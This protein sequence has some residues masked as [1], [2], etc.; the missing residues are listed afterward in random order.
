MKKL[1]A[2]AALALALILALGLSSC[3]KENPISNEEIFDGAN[4]IRLNGFSAEYNGSPVEE[5]DYTWHCDPAA[6]HEEDKNAPA[7]YHTGNKPETDAPVYIDGDLPYFPLL[8]ESGFQLV[9]YDGEQEW[10][11]YYTAEGLRQYIFATLPRLGNALPTQM[12]HSEEEAAHNR[13][14]HIT[15]AGKYVL[16]G[17]WQGQIRVELGDADDCFADENAKVEIILNGVE[18]NCTVAPGLLF[19]SAYECDNGWEDRSEYTAEPDLSAAGI[20]VWIADGT[21]NSVSGCNIYRML[22]TKYKDDNSGDEIKVQKKQRKLDGAFY[23]CVSMVICGG[24]KGNGTLTV[25]SSFEGLDS[26]LHLLVQGGNI[27]INSQDDGINVN[28]DGV[29]TAMFAGGALTINAGL[30]AEG[31]GVDSNG[32]IAVQG[33]TLCINNVTPPDSALDSDCGTYYYGGTVIIDGQ[34]QNYQK[35]SE[36]KEDGPGMPGGPGNMGPGG[37]PEQGGPADKP[38]ERPEN[39]GPGGKPEQGSPADKPGEWPEN[40]GPG[41]QPGEIPE[42][43]EGGS[44][45][46]GEMPEPPEGKPGENGANG[47]NS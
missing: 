9:N 13:V 31:D 42:P 11:Y 45:Q 4:N 22:K 26:E 23:S 40:M 46:P 36:I 44:G 34:T 12:M 20:T 2:A 24:E 30:G 27:T 41:G 19:A 25:N 29:S 43:S 21:E 5:F 1:K 37:K 14:L 47:P 3:G 28:E 8:E 17:N 7:E 33:G 16:E 6:V 35:G 10:V 39:M 32:F 15:K 38:G 18:I